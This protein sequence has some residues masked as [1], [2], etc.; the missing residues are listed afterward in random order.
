MD[1][2]LDGQLSLS[3]ARHGNEAVS[4]KYSHAKAAQSEE[5]RREG[6]TGAVSGTACCR[7]KQ[8]CHSSV[9]ASTCAPSLHQLQRVQ[10][11]KPLLLL[12]L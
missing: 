6:E 10:V 1:S 5:L 7:R 9:P 2:V 3:G 11:H 12:C 4:G 8:Q